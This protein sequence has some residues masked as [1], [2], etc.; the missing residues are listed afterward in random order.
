VTVAEARARLS[1]A[2]IA[3]ADELIAA[4]PPLTPGQERLIRRCLGPHVLPLDE[5]AA[6]APTSPRT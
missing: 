3:A 6:Q 5:A 2:A 4:A 1:P